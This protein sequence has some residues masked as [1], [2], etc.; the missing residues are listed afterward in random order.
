[1][2][3]ERLHKKIAK[4]PSSFET[5]YKKDITVII[6]NL[7]E[8]YDIHYKDTSTQVQKAII[9]NKFLLILGSSREDIICKGVSQNGNKC[10]R[11]A[12]DGSEYCK[13]HSYLEFRQNLT[14][15]KQH[16]EQQNVLF[17]IENENTNNLNIDKSKLSKTLIEDTF[18]YTDDSF[19]YNT[20]S[21]E[22]VGYVEHGK[23]FLTDD[24]FILCI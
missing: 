8:E 2:E 12:Q 7:F 1:M 15:Q 24:P 14:T 10:C 22:R 11:K 19:V 23:F 5:A 9:L 21:L 3:L 17:V 4:I 20:D 18:Y 6:D 13:T 16:S